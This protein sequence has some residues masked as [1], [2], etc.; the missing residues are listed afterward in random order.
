MKAAG[1]SLANTLPDFDSALKLGH[2]GSLELA[3]DNFK[4]EKKKGIPGIGGSNWD[5]GDET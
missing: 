4:S 3:W 2:H 5:R 1:K